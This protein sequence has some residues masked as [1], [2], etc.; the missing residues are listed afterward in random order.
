M[1][2]SHREKSS[3]IESCRRCGM[4]ARG[5]RALCDLAQ[6]CA[7]VMRCSNLWVESEVHCFHCRAHTLDTASL[8]WVLVG[9][10]YVTVSSAM[11]VSVQYWE[12]W[13][14]ESPPSRGE[15]NCLFTSSP[16]NKINQLGYSVIKCSALWP[17]GLHKLLLANNSLLTCLGPGKS[18]CTG[19]G[20][21]CSY[22]RGNSF[23]AWTI[24]SALNITAINCG[25]FVN[26][27]T[28]QHFNPYQPPKETTVT[29]AN[30]WL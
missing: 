18:S 1:V 2:K 10:L 11:G 21:I 4:Y 24:S 23:Q 12:G 6:V 8:V 30:W 26:S 27:P 29:D 3:V 9:T 16:N 25:A 28:C 14:R 20:R 22:K 19:P 7:S 15:M 17:G 13:L 5:G